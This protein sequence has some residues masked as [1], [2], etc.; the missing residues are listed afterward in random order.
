M[1]IHNNQRPLPSSGLLSGDLASFDLANGCFINVSFGSRNFVC[2]ITFSLFFPLA[3]WAMML[4]DKHLY[5]AL[6]WSSFSFWDLRF[7]LLVLTLFALY[8]EVLISFALYRLIFIFLHSCRHRWSNVVCLKRRRY[9]DGNASLQIW[10]QNT[11]IWNKNWRQITLRNQY[12]CWSNAKVSFKV[13]PNLR[14][15]VIF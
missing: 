13:G 12:W 7:H 4:N 11:C 3:G 5:L 6:F 1:I 14:Y 10:A 2:L 9:C 8:H 15:D